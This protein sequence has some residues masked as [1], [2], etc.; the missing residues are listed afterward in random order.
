[1]SRGRLR[2]GMPAICWRNCFVPE[3]EQLWFD[4]PVLAHA[5]SEWAMD[6]HVAPQLLA[7]PG[8]LL[9]RHRARLA[10]HASGFLGCTEKAAARALW[11]LG[12]GDRFLRATRVPLALHRGAR[13]LDASMS[14]RF[15]HYISETARRLRQVNRVI[16]GESP[17]WNAEP[18]RRDAWKHFSPLL[19]GMTQGLAL[20]Q[21]LF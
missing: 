7:F 3:H 14:R 17:A 4:Y 16:D 18:D 2:W 19:R 8:E 13:V 10:R 11:Y 20:P 6:A 1:M 5:A 12:N 21:D 15:D 9:R